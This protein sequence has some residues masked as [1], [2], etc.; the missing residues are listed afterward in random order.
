[1][2]NK[3]CPAAGP[4]R[5][6]KMDDALFEIFGALIFQTHFTHFGESE[7]QY[8]FHPLFIVEYSDSTYTG[9]AGKQKSAQQESGANGTMSV[10]NNVHPVWQRPNCPLRCRT[11]FGIMSAET[12]KAVD[13]YLTLLMQGHSTAKCQNPTEGFIEYYDEFCIDTGWNCIKFSCIVCRTDHSLYFTVASFDKD[14]SEFNS[15]AEVRYPADVS[16]VPCLCVHPPH[17]ISVFATG[18]PRLHA[19]LACAVGA[20]GGGRAAPTSRWKGG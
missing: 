1:M 10:P 18:F 20:L 4:P 7:L 2:R 12:R 6:Q 15:S 9:F 8:K 3:S 17:P 5:S 16:Y 19:N 11:E 14:F 13:E